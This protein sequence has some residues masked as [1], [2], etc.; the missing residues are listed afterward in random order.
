MKPAGPLWC[1]VFLGVCLVGC[2]RSGLERPDPFAKLGPAA[3]I[4][5]TSVQWMGGVEAWRDVD[6]I[7]ASAVVTVHE[8]DGRAHVSRER[9]RIY[10]HSGK[11]VA[12]AEVGQGAWRAEVR[13]GGRS[14]LRAR[15][16]EPDAEM[17]DRICGALRTILHRVRGPLNLL[18]P[19]RQVRSVERT[20][21]GDEDLVRVVV[22][23]PDGRVLSYY[24]QALSGDLRL[25]TAGFDSGRQAGTVTVYTYRMLPEGMA[26]P[27]QIRVVKSGENVLLSDQPVLDVRFSQVEIH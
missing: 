8:D 16:F 19:G 9:Q 6:H 11:L 7:D 18:R 2:E 24:F 15:G 14:R 5:S 25:V 26:F 10:V 13:D 12:T 21:L 4:V 23:G 1:L 3:E 17:K 20:R 22:S 27:Q